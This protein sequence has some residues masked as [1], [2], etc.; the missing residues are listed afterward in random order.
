MLSSLVPEV[1]CTMSVE[2]PLMAAARCSETQVL[3]VPGT[4]RSRRARS[5]ARV[6][7]ATSMRRRLPT[8]FGVMGVPS[9]AVPPRR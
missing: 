3:A 7:M 8:Y 9:G 6:A 1:P 2:S 5:V 4:P